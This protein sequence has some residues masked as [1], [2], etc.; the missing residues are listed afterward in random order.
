VSSIDGAAICLYNP[1]QKRT[2]GKKF[3]VSYKPPRGVIAYTWYESQ[4]DS[5]DF[6]FFLL[7]LAPGIVSCLIHWIATLSSATSIIDAP[8]SQVY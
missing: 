6:F 1:T 7:N 3:M 5:N 8:V 4:H 2:R